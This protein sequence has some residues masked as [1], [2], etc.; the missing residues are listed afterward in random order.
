M[1]KDVAFRI[2][3][4]DLNRFFDLVEKEAPIKERDWLVYIRVT[5]YMASFYAGGVKAEY[6]VLAISR[7]SVQVVRHVLKSVVKESKSKEVELIFGDEYVTSGKKS[8]DDVSISPGYESHDAHRTTIYPTF[9]ELAVLSRNLDEEQA[10]ELGLLE[11]LQQ[12]KD[13]LKTRIYRATKVL[14]PLGVE[15]T[16]VEALIEAAIARSE[17]RIKVSLALG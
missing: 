2:R 11:R 12:T 17:E 9:L 14:E 3:R 10:R 6:P 16:E 1:G 13:R 7:G 4:L 8:I 15:E 5:E